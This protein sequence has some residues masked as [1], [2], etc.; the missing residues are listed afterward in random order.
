M[1]PPPDINTLL[2]LQSKAAA[3]FLDMAEQ[4][5]LIDRPGKQTIS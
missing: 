4:A 3:V 5:N 2:V 1:A